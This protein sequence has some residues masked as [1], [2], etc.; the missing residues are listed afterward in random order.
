[1]I[2]FIIGI[3]CLILGYFLYGSVVERI[4]AP[5]AEKKTPCYTMEDGVDYT[6]MPTWKVFLIQF[7]NI[8]GTGPIFG[9]I[10]GILFGPA[11][12][13]WIVLGCIFGGAVH[14]YM[15][16]MISIKR[17]G[18]SLP[19]II[20]DELGNTARAA[21]RFLSLFL[22]ILV[23]AVFV[24]TPAGLLTSMTGNIASFDGY[25]FWLVVIFAYYL[26]AAILPINKV[27]GKIYPIFG[28]M[29]IFMAVCIFF[30]IFMH[31]S[32]AMPEI[33]EA[34]EN[35]YPGG[36]L[37][38]FPGLCITIACGAVSGFHATQSPM[39][40]RCMKNE[41][42]GRRIFYGSMITE[43]V[44]AMIWA[45]AAIQFASALDVD[46]STPYEKLLNA[47]LETKAD[48]S[49]T[50]NP[51]I[52]VN[53]I[54]RDWL[55]TFGA[56]LA[57][58]GVVFAPITTGDTALRSARLIIAD[59]FK[60]PQ[61][62]VLRRVMLCI[63]IFAISVVLLF[64]KFDVLWRYFAWFNQTFSI[65]T[66]FAITVYLAKQKKPYIITLIPGMFMMMVCVTYICIDAHS[67]NLGQSVS[68]GVGLTSAIVTLI[69]FLVW[70]RNTVD[71]P[72]KIT[73]SP[74]QDSVRK[75]VEEVKTLL[76]QY[77]VAKEKIVIAVLVV[78]DFL[79]KA[80]NKINEGCDI[81]L[82]IGHTY[83]KTTLKINYR[84]KQADPYT[85]ISDSDFDDIEKQYGPEALNAVKEMLVNNQSELLNMQYSKE[86][87]SISVTVSKDERAALI[88]SLIAIGLGAVVGAI[89]RLM[90]PDNVG[91]IIFSELFMP[92][93]SLFLSAIKMIMLPML[94]FSLA[95]MMASLTGLR[96]FGRTGSKVMGFYIMTTVIAILITLGINTLIGQGM[97]NTLSSE[98]GAGA[99]TT[100]LG[101]EVIDIIITTRTSHFLNSSQASTMLQVM[102]IAICMGGVA[103]SLNK[104]SD[105]VK[106]FIESGRAVFHRIISII[107][108]FM[109][110]AV[111]G[112][113]ANIVMTFSA[114]ALMAMLTWVGLC[115][116]A[117][118][119][120]IIVYIAILASLSNIGVMKVLKAFAP[121]LWHA[122][123]TASSRATM[124]YMVRAC[125]QLNI[126]PHLYSFTMPFG[127]NVKMDGTCIF[128]VSAVLVL[129]MVCGVN[130][131]G[132]TLLMVL[133][134][135]AILSMAT[136]GVTGAA[137]AC[138]TML[139][140]MADVPVESIAIILCL[141]PLIDPVLTLLN[142]MGN[143]VVTTVLLPPVSG[144]ELPHE[145]V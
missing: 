133:V 84:G 138:I 64:V 37:P 42:L 24:K 56:I 141:T 45:A 71:A 121:S 12:Y 1:M 80:L 129:A 87:N 97:F 135:A 104:Y 58:L 19:E 23:V 98:F 48:G 111:F 122:F 13:F 78:E 44:M 2:T 32:S 25:T 39:M 14:D 40:A 15:A 124:P 109:P 100:G 72:V 68:Y 3:A 144:N 115:F 11:A 102:F 128:Y 53:W 49:T 132:D 38:L 134:A 26:I 95:S 63:P 110:V 88:D 57:V 106:T 99:V 140:A 8:A 92:L 4:A 142:V 20:G 28:V 7:L 52:L 125:H 70:K 103:N 47:M 36:T 101:I 21:Q 86:L 137:F 54:C 143:I 16:G 30:G 67:L 22:M 123:T 145:E 136:P 83:R 139:L 94:A 73:V 75:A 108:R 118:I 6:P 114:D 82:S 31:D 62:K 27:I 66:F 5:D 91:S 117:V 77:N 65:F 41:R 107:M 93:Y 96:S 43:G 59:M 18:A 120:M 119:G 10:Q 131:S 81:D 112:A 55:G 33:T 46:G 69:W 50:M 116:G 90:V 29:L 76:E 74:D 130:L 127:T 34:F 17:N 113:M 79:G 105:P 85:I 35:H 61:D 60:I 51:A 89:M 126:A 9:T